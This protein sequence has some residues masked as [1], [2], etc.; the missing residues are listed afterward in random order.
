M[1]EL[2]EHLRHPSGHP[3]GTALLC[4]LIAVTLFVVDLT[5]RRR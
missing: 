5:R 3:E 1:A 2:L 4:V